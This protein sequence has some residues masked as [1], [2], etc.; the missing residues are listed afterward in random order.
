MPRK[1]NSPAAA[2]ENDRL[3]RSPSENK[4]KRENKRKKK[5]KEERLKFFLAKKGIPDAEWSFEQISCIND[6]G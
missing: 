4:G 5:N 1:T 6:E 3:A 2:E